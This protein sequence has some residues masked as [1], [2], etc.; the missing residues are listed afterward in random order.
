MC[1]AGTSP[2]WRGSAWTSTGQPKERFHAQSGAE[3]ARRQGIA[4]IV[5]GWTGEG[6]EGAP[7]AVAF[8]LT[9]R[10]AMNTDDGFVVGTGSMR[11]VFTGPWPS[12]QPAE[13]VGARLEAQGLSGGDQV[14]VDPSSSP[15][16]FL[17]DLGVSWRG[18]EGRREWECAGGNLA[19]V[20][21]HDG[22]GR[23]HLQV[24]LGM[25]DG[26]EPISDGDWRTTGTLELEPGGLF[27]LGDELATFLR[28]P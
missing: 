25:Y 8:T 6:P 4:S 26:D 21:W 12:G 19:L 10:P 22:I 9:Y 1:S 11:L 23:V 3:S 24:T 17:R 13:Y 14:A 5:E 7:I 18:W 27:Q 2:L 28:H 15:A 16:N 20:A